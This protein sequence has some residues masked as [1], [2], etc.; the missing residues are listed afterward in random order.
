MSIQP[1]IIER[2]ADNGEHSHWQLVNSEGEILW[3]E[4]PTPQ[5]NDKNIGRN[6]RRESI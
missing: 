5:R 2:F 1:I 4:D 6:L 3:S